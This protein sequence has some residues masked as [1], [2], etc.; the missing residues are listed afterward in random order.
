MIARFGVDKLHVYSH[1][2]AAALDATLEDVTDVQLASDRLN[3]ER[4]SLVTERR[5][6]GDHDRA[7]YA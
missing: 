5:V 1:A 2:G 3:I 7:P 4:L 6:A